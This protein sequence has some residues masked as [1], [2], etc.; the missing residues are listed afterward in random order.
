MSSIQ[1]KRKEAALFRAV[2]EI[3]SEDITNANVSYTTVTGV[4]LSNDGSHL[5]IFVTF[6]N[7][8]ERSLEA[9]RNT[10]GYI[11]KVISK[12]PNLRKSPQV[13]FEIDRA[14]EEGN[15]IERI[16]QKIKEDENK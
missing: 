4:E 7:S 9:L 3:I 14:I 1:H 12:M 15:K 13:H 5:K 2:S 16:L 10:A 8:P 6:E 11:R